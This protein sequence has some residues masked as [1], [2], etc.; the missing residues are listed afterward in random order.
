MLENDCCLEA[1]MAKDRF[2]ISLQCPKCKK[3]G[4]GTLRTSRW[5]GVC[6][7]KYRS[8]IE[9]R[10]DIQ[11]M[12]RHQIMTMYSIRRYLYLDQRFAKIQGWNLGGS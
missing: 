7:G 10:E 11:F 9:P 2:T 4:V 8:V 6:E 1:G 3:V 12:V 5:L